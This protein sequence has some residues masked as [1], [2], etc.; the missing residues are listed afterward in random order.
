[1]AKDCDLEIA[2]ALET[3]LKAIQWI[4]EIEICAICEIWE[5]WGFKCNVKTYVTGLPIKCYSINTLFMGALLHNK[6]ITSQWV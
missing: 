1:M 2:R 5:K 6:I 3:Q 4:I